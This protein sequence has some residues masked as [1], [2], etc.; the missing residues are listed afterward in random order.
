M[1]P[2]G[3]Y[4]TMNGGSVTFNVRHPTGAEDSIW[5]AVEDAIRIGMTPEQFKREVAQAWEGTL[6]RHARE[7]VAAI[8]K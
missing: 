7:A 1:K 6:E 4:A 5:E 3:I 2:P 8:L